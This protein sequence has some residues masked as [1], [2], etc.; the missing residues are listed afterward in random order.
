[1]DSG[2]LDAV[3]A[4]YREVFERMSRGGTGAPVVSFSCR[5]RAPGELREAYTECM[6]TQRLA[7]DLGMRGSFLHYES[8]DLAFVFEGV[9]ERRMR[10]FCDRWLGK[11]QSK[12]QEYVQEMLRTL[13]MYLECDGQVG[14]TA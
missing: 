10:M 13:E 3:E 8:L 2:G 12:D 1:R 9:T 7:R 6:D 4:A 14:E 11:L 5:K